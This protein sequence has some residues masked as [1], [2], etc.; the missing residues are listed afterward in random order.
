MATWQNMCAEHGVQTPNTTQRYPD[1]I[2]DD[3]DVDDGRRK[4]RER[5]KDIAKLANHA[6]C[7]Y[8]FSVSTHRWMVA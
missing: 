5:D 6:A 1:R 3:G 2:D 7:I 8:T 4:E